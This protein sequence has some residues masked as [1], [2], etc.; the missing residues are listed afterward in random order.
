MYNPRGQY[1][2]P[3]TLGIPEKWER[4]LCYALGWITGLIFLLVEQRNGTVRRHAM[5]SLIVFGGLSILGFV[6]GIFSGIPLL[7]FVFLIL[8]RLVGFVGFVAWIGLMIG[9]Y[10][11]PVTF[12]DTGTTHY[13]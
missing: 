11:S 4:V 9:A 3:T 2:S 7:S 13:V 10:V 1:S 6:L 5:Q 8:A 12:I